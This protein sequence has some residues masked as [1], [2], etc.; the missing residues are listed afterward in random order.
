MLELLKVLR[1]L[2]TACL[3]RVVVRCP[4]A[5]NCPYVQALQQQGGCGVAPP[6]TGSIEDRLV[7]AVS[8]L[9]K[10][11]GVAEHN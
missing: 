7:W 11:Y 1:A 2:A 10:Q 9:E 3:R 4:R 5:A 8:V 6:P